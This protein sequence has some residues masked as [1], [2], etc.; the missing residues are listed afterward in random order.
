MSVEVFQYFYTSGPKKE[1]NKFEQFAMVSTQ[2]VQK[3][4]SSAPVNSCELDPLPAPVLK[5]SLDAL[6]NFYIL[7]L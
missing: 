7:K 1:K 4:I 2:D 3:I 5:A 6:D